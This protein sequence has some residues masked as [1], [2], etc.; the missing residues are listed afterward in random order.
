MKVLKMTTGFPYGEDDAT[1][2]RE[3]EIKDYLSQFREVPA[4]EYRSAAHIVSEV[5]AAGAL[6]ALGCYDFSK[7]G[8]KGAV[9]L[10]DTTSV[11]TEE[12]HNILSRLQVAAAK[13]EVQSAIGIDQGFHHQPGWNTKAQSPLSGP[14]L[15]SF[16][17]LMLCQDYC[18]DA[19]QDRLNEG[20]RIVAVCPQE[21]RRPD[22]V[23]G[24]SMATRLPEA[25]Q[26]G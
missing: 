14:V 9:E 12:L 24:R 8:I 25:A 21:A 1:K 10:Y 6:V 16:D 3:Q 20:W 2:Q 23:L 11:H 5:E 17:E 13:L 4:D 22:Y 7:G 15:H 18:T 26:R 19:L